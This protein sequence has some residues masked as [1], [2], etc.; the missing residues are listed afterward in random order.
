MVDTRF[1]L[2]SGPSALP[3]LLEAV[4]Q[5]MAVDD[6]RLAAPDHRRRLASSIPPAPTHIALAASKDYVDALRADRRGRG[7]RRPEPS[8]VRA[9]DGHP[10]R[11]RAAARA[12][13]R[14]ARPALSRRHP[15]LGQGDGRRHLRRAADR[16]GRARRREC[17]PGPGVEIGSGTLHRAQQRHR[18]GRRHRP[19][20]HDRPQLHHRMRLC[21]QQRR[22]PRRRADRHR[23][24]RL[25]RFRPDQHAR[26]RSSAA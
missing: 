17:R 8:R 1:H 6:E 12:L 26:S 3:A 19:R 15:R 13:R 24:F 11:R 21:R 20:Q 10:D 7:H 23:G 2:F 18:P 14:S 16:G 22:A 4:G 5:A 25:A 9:R